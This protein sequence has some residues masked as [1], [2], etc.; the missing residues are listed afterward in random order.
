MKRILLIANYWHFEEE[1][2]SSRY[3]SMADLISENGYYLEVITSSF[4][5]LT[6]KQRD[7]SKLNIENL[8]Y[9]VTLL[10]EPG[11]RKNISAKRLYSHHEF[12]K[13]IKKYLDKCERPDLI[14]VSVPSLSVGSVVT[15]YAN[16]NNIKVIVDIQDLWPESF[17]MAIDIPVISDILFFPMMCQANNIYRRADYIMAV[18]DTFVQRGLKYNKKDTKGLSLYIGSDSNL[19]AR[20]KA[21]IK[22]NKPENEFWIGYVGALGRSYDLKVVID[23]INILYSKGFNSIKFIVMGDGPLKDEF[24]KYAIDKKI[25]CDFKGFMNYGEMMATLEVC[26]VAVNPIDGKSVS[27][28]INKVSDY[29]LAGVPVINTQNSPEYRKLL[30]KYNAGINCK[31]GDSTSVSLAIEELLCDSSKRIAMKEN[32]LNLGN[33]KFDRMKTYS[34]VI[35]LINTVLG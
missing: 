29:A 25:D 8:P 12:A 30:E 16:K 34:A 24:N 26:D 9:K 2:A 7:V 1:K 18:S 4:R 11:Y 3:R 28:I 23:A 32:S 6:K 14:I 22:V 17:K 31:N 10:H 21:G 13:N 35:N 33:K 15:R 19:V 5:H 20:E 27:S